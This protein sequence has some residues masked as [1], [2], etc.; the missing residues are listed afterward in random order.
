MGVDSYIAE[1]QMVDSIGIGMIDQC[2][3]V[4]MVVWYVLLIHSTYNRGCVVGACDGRLAMGT[5][6]GSGGESGTRVAV[7]ST[8]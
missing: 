6:S 8:V 3:M 2:G 1:L 5:G 4:L 7:P